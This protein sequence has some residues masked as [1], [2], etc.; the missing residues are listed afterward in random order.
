MAV[1]PDG[2]LMQR[3]AAG[4]ASV[5]AGLLRDIVGGVYGALGGSRATRGLLRGESAD[6]L[7]GFVRGDYLAEEPFWE[8]VERARLRAHDSALRIRRGDVR[9]DPKG[10][11]CPS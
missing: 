11:E 6:D 8:I 4:L 5:C 1:V 2:A 3:A 10:G 7:P 9:H